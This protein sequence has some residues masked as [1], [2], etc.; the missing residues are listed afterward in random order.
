M[1]RRRPREGG[2]TGA[3]SAHIRVPLPTRRAKPYSRTGRRDRAQLSSELCRPYFYAS[4][5]QEQTSAHAAFQAFG[6]AYR[7]ACRESAGERRAMN[8]RWPVACRRARENRL[9]C[10]RAVLPV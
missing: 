10:S 3:R 2:I 5:P 1:S 6:G 4:P 8:Q 7:A 9:S